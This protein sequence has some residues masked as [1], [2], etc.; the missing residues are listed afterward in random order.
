MAVN[1]D[2]VARLA[3]LAKQHNTLLV[4]FSTDWGS[5]H[6]PWRESDRPAQLNVDGQSKLAGEQAILACG[7]CYLIIRTRWLH[8]SWRDNF[9]KTML[10]ESA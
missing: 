6:R 1:V 9:L 7:Y 10:R 2:R 4:H 8:S 3:K 5:G